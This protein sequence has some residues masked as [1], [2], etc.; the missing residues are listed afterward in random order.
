MKYSIALILIGLL[1]Y[2]C[3]DCT[4]V[5]CIN[6]W[7]VATVNLRYD[8]GQIG[9]HTMDSELRIENVQLRKLGTEEIEKVLVTQDS[10]AL[11]FY[12]MDDITY[13][14]QVLDYVPI[15]IRALT[16]FLEEGECC[17]IFRTKSILVNGELACGVDCTEL[18]L[19][20][21]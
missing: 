14:L 11:I 5:D 8:S 3:N 18:I 6:N 20:I 1:S 19:D 15:E 4:H 12:L 21:K 16:E 7:V 13:E 2:S 9:A 10:S 17:E